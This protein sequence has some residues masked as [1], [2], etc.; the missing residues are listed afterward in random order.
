MWHH[1]VQGIPSERRAEA[2][3]PS[4]L[5]KQRLSL[6]AGR[7]RQRLGRL[8][9]LAVKAGLE[10]T[11]RTRYAGLETKAARLRDDHVTHRV[12]GSRWCKHNVRFGR[13]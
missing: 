7:P 1:R 11:R 9:K 13:R 2:A 3:K 10:P 5:F 12:C 4:I 6:V 8:I